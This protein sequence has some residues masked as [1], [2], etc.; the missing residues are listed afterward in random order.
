MHQPPKRGSHLQLQVSA[1]SESEVGL[2]QQ[3]NVLQQFC[4]ERG[5]IVNVKKTKVMVFNFID[6]CQEFVFEGDAIEHVQTFKY[7]GILLKTTSNLDCAVEHLVATSRR[8]LFTLLCGATYYE[9]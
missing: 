6:P 7:M 3:L 8:S 5:L 9:C 2:Q 4:V 1:K